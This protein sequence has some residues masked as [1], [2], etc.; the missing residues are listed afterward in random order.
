MTLSPGV[1]CAGGGGD[2]RAEAPVS[3]TAR[4]QE[5]LRKLAMIDETFVA[6]QARLGL[7]PA[8]W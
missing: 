1:R 5:I 7:G 3:E 4:F 8:C 6:D 2:G